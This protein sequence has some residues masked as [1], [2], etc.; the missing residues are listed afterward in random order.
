MQKLSEQ[1]CL[2]H[3]KK[4]GTVS[5]IES[6]PCRIGIHQGQWTTTGCQLRRTCLDCGASHHREKHSWSRPYQV[7]DSSRELRRTCYDCG[8]TMSV[9]SSRFSQA[10]FAL[11]SVRDKCL[12]SLG[13]HQGEW[14]VVGCQQ[15]RHCIYCRRL[16]R[17]ERHSWPPE[18]QREYF[19]DGSCEMRVTCLRCG[20]TKSL[21]ITHE[22]AIGWGNPTCKRCGQGMGGGGD[23]GGD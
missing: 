2:P 10:K 20:Q 19:Q 11:L 13:M 21:G 17:R 18:Y 23:P 22:D 3:E 4:E 5:F 6:L 9:A 12:C 1:S 14:I 16:Q 7:S 15:E 8:T